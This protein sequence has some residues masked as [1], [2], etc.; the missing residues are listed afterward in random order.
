M[1]DT[2]QAWDEVVDR[3]ERLGLRLKLHLEQAGTGEEEEKALQ[4]LGAAIDQAFDALSN[5]ARDTVVQRDVTELGRTL[6]DALGSSLANI[7][8]HRQRCFADGRRRDESATSG[9][10]G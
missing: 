8:E 4:R 3:F 6:G 2:K 10:S 1:T 7:S 9:D 5:A